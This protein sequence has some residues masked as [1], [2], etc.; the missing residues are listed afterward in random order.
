MGRREDIGQKRNMPHG[1]SLY[2]VHPSSFFYFGDW[3]YASSVFASEHVFFFLLIFIRVLLPVV[4][5]FF[6]LSPINKM[7]RGRSGKEWRNETSLGYWIT[8]MSVS[9]N[10]LTPRRLEGFSD[11]VD[12]GS[13]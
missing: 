8:G 13:S 11:E 12:I 1:I 2:Y 6:L 3:V 9:C 4:L 7:R 10:K 5:F